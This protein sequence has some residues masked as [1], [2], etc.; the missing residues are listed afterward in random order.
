MKITIFWFRRDLRIDDNTALW[1]ALSSGLPVMPIFIFDTNIIDELKQDDPR[2]SFIYKN[3]AELDFI[4]K[5][6]GSSLR[7]LKSTPEIAF[8]KLLTEFDVHSVYSNRDYE[9]YAISRDSN[10]SKILN[11]LGLQFFQFKDHVIFE[12]D[13]ILKGNDEPYTIFTPYKNQWLKKFGE[14][15]YELKAVEPL[16]KNLFSFKSEFPGLKEL[17]FRISIIEV[18]NYQFD[19]IQNYAQLR[20]LPA[21]DATTYLGPHLRFGTISIRQLIND[22]GNSRDRKS[23]RLNSS[24]QSTSRMPSSA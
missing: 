20:D 1:N 17:G 8:E 23:T 14:Q 7:I 21:D 12:Q 18:K 13:E 6:F 15:A 9:P 24:H 19:A 3:L 11:K 22:I 16:L 2:I 5:K 10:V 4:F